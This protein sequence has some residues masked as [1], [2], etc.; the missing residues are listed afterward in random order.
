[1]GGS[2]YSKTDKLR[3]APFKKKEKEKKKKTRLW[4]DFQT[5][6]LGKPS[7]GDVECKKSLNL[8]MPRGGDMK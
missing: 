5:F 2:P 4:A 1:M 7:L 3:G 8:E 6:G